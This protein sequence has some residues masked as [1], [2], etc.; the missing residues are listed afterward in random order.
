MIT[1]DDILKKASRKYQDVLRSWIIAD[2]SL[3]PMEFPVGKLSDNLIKRR[4][5]IEILRDKSHEGV[6][7]GYTLEWK[8]VNKRDLGKQTI[9]SRIVIPN[10]GEYLTLL[11]RKTEF[12]DFTTDATKITNKFPQLEAWLVERP[13]EVIAY[14]GRWDDILL[15]CDYFCKYPRP[16]VYIRELPIAVHTKFIET[17]IRILRDLLDILLPTDAIK[18]EDSNFTI[19]YG[20]HD[21]PTLVRVRLLEE[22]MDWQFGLRIDDLT[23]P[24]S[25]LSHLLSEHLKPKRIIIVENLINFLTLP[26][27]ANSIGIFGGGFGVHVLREV[28]WLNQ[29]QIIYWGDID[30]HGFQ[31]L[32]DLREIF[33]HTQS[34]MMD[35]YTYSTYAQ[36]TVKGKQTTDSQF[37]SLTPNENALAQY[38]YEQNIRLEQEHIPQD[39]AVSQLNHLIH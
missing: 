35:Q 14:Q 16:N 39:Y 27:L 29:C 1:P 8:T 18:T 2:A 33:P 3:F 32:S 28:D 22:Q 13:H 37:S 34:V 10:R 19:R 9:P 20:L 21:K 4:T 11:R 17:H 12:N 31:I 15:V 38:V 5:E 26:Q 30:A 6:G 36:Y 7:Y 24:V 23:L 25:Q